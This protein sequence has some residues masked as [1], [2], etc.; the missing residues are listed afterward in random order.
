MSAANDIAGRPLAPSD[1][2]FESVTDRLEEE[3]RLANALLESGD[4]PSD[5][6]H[7]SETEPG[8]I[9]RRGDVVAWD[10]DPQGHRI[11]VSMAAVLDA[12]EGYWPH[13]RAA[14]AV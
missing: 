6:V 9:V 3:V 14:V 10:Y 8:V 11:E 4:D 5:F 7:G 13:P 12:D 2:H 1:T